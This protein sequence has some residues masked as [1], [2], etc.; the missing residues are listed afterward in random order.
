MSSFLSKDVGW[1]MHVATIRAMTEFNQQVDEH[2]IWIC[3]VIAAAKKTSANDV[4]WLPKAPSSKKTR[5]GFDS[6]TGGGNEDVPERATRSSKRLKEKKSV[7]LSANGSL[8]VKDTDIDKVTAV[9]RPAIQEGTRKQKSSSYSQKS[10]TAVSAGRSVEVPKEALAASALSSRRDSPKVLPSACCWF[11]S[12]D[13]E[14]S[15]ATVAIFSPK[16]LGDHAGTN[17]DTTPAQKIE[18][19]SDDIVESADNKS[20]QRKTFPL[21]TSSNVM[22]A[23]EESADST[24]HPSPPTLLRGFL[25]LYMH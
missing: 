24:V 23:P 10:S 21:W 15:M 8:P 6:R 12:W 13:K 16:K 3:E 4:D 17:Y 11:I 22:L 7:D 14:E 25:D 2:R 5:Q 9:N 19:P 1:S 18:K 20:K